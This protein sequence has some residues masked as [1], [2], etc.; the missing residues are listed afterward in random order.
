MK[1]LSVILFAIF[2]SSMAMQ[3]KSK[4]NN[5]VEEP[6]SP[7]IELITGSDSASYALGVYMGKQMS[8]QLS[9]SDY[10]L[11]LFVQALVDAIYDAPLKISPDS[12]VMFLNAYEKKLKEQEAAETIQRGESFLAEN[13]KREG[14]QTTASG[15]Q[16][17]V[18]KMGDGAKPIAS[19]KVKV[20]YEGFLIDGKKFDSSIDRG[21]P[22]EFTLNRV[23][24]GWTEGLQLM[25]VGSKFTFYIPYN[26]A[27][28]TQG[29]GNVIPPYS[30][31]IFE[32][33]LLDIVK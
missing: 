13:A 32:V 31:L 12:A 14:V 22:T 21:Q 28:G 33:E 18:V 4:K 7:K 8:M 1:R 6:V 15:L 30:T 11:S 10:N 27:Y 9:S 17:Q 23:I 16:Y 24:K 19:D 29:A 25:P 26:L 3:A 20:H 5:K 2:I